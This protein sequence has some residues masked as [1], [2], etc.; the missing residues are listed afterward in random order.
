M[1][2]G[3]TVAGGD[4]CVPNPF[5]QLR[6]AQRGAGTD[7]TVSELTEI[8]LFNVSVVLGELSRTKGL[9]SAGL[10]SSPSG[11]LRSGSNVGHVLRMLFSTSPLLLL[12][13]LLLFFF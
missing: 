12:L 8:V 6:K 5:W 13:L 11:S 9:G 7:L 4:V 2:M 1:L 3:Y 10:G